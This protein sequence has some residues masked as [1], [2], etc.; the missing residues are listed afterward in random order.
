[1]NG[2]LRASV[3][4]IEYTYSIGSDHSIERDLSFSLPASTS[5]NPTQLQSM[6]CVWIE[7]A[8]LCG[9]NRVPGRSAWLVDI[10]NEEG[11]KEGRKGNCSASNT[12]RASVRAGEE[13]SEGR[14][15]GREGVGT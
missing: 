2:R 5:I 7:R 14:E 10:D 8:S 4:A 13:A 11:R 3:F 1:M 9:R 6:N 12:E 15:G